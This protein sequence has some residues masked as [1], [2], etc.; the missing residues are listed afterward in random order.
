MKRIAFVIGFGI[1][2]IFFHCNPANQ[3]DTEVIG[4]KE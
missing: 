2:I 1:A 3:A 4:C